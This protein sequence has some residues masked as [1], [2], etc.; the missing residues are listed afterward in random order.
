MAGFPII[1]ER[2]NPG[3]WLAKPEGRLD[4]ANHSC[5]SHRLVIV[6]STRGHVHMR[7]KKLH[8]VYLILEERHL[9]TWFQVSFCN[10][11]TATHIR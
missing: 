2:V 10:L 3:A 7:V 9:H 1:P 4:Y 8:T 5:I 11:V 6:S